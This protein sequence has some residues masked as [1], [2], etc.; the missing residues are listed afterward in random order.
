MYLFFTR[1][2]P[3][4]GLYSP[5]QIPARPTHAGQYSPVLGLSFSV[6]ISLASILTT[7]HSGRAA[8]VDFHTLPPRKG[9]ENYYHQ[10]KVPI[11]FDT[12]EHRLRNHEFTTLSEL[13]SYLKRMVQNCK[14][15][16]PRES[17]I[18]K[19][20]E[21]I[22]KL[23]TSWMNTH[24]PAY[25]DRSANYAPYPTV[26]TD[27]LVAS[28]PPPPYQNGNGVDA[29][30][31]DVDMEEGSGFDSR[32]S[33]TPH[34]ETPGSTT[35]KE[36][37]SLS[38]KAGDR[39]RRASS[40]PAPTTITF[41]GLTFQQAQEKILAEMAEEKD[42][43][44]DEI[45][46]YDIFARLPDR[47][48]FKDYYAVIPHPVSFATLK[49]GIKGGSS[50]NTKFTTWDE[51]DEE[52]SLI[53]KNAR[54]YNEDGSF[55]SE[56]AGELEVFFN[57]RFRAAKK[58]VP[59]PRHAQKPQ[60]KLKLNA[61]PSYEQALTPRHT[62]RLN[63][64]KDTPA[65]SPA[66][67]PVSTTTNNSDT[68]PQRRASTIARQPSLV[69]AP[70][71][72]SVSGNTDGDSSEAEEDTLI[73]APVV[74]P[75]QKIYPA[76]PPTTTVQQQPHATPAPLQITGNTMAPPA[77]GMQQINTVNGM[78]P[79]GAP[80]P[81]QAPPTPKP[82]AAPPIEFDSKW[83]LPGKSKFTSLFWIWRC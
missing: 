45:P 8:T 81:V 48:L 76:L 66:L 18:H 53:W 41:N 68:V 63:V 64:A 22:R 19:D 67:T 75:E 82:V 69:A 50:G 6:L 52:V 11:A 59:E 35:R 1:Y 21:R 47:K 37:P 10:T 46:K 28:H 40:T 9:N 16:Y 32:P 15:Y 77:T 2:A 83:R 25:A 57:K 42:D 49:R 27:E 44:D 70:T 34:P 51:F 60:I 24:N 17:T 29:D 61:G 36:R 54:H 5:G 58:V 20:A 56:L 7:Y 33:T 43:A 30:A 71:P 65:D 55:I 38:A 79:D 26:I 39:H 31:E 4:H 3:S 73:V 14:D 23:T 78:I 80:I 74:K 12:V 72:T 13:E 62:L